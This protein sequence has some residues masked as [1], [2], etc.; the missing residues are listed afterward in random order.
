MLID[1]LAE[2]GAFAIKLA[3]DL[4]F[5]IAALAFVGS[6]AIIVALGLGGLR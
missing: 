3:I 6:L 1:L 4:F 2:F 5:F